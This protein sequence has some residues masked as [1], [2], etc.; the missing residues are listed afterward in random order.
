[1]K[2]VV[3]PNCKSR[4]IRKVRR[5]WTGKFHGKTYLVPALEYYECPH[6]G[7]KI[8]DRQAMRKIESYSPAFSRNPVERKTA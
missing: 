4:E 8:Y 1:M 5:N 6:C 3:C 7:E 2:I